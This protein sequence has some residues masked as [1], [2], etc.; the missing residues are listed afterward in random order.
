MEILEKAVNDRG[1]LE[2]MSCS[3]PVKMLEVEGF[4]QKVVRFTTDIPQLNSWQFS[5][6]RGLSRICSSPVSGRPG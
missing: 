1:E 5:R 2:V 4:N 3:L 6:L